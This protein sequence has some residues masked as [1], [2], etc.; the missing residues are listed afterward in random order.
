ML[1]QKPENRK[2]N[3]CIPKKTDGLGRSIIVFPFVLTEQKGQ[4]DAFSEIL[5]L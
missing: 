3:A 2:K 5:L 4:I 1:A